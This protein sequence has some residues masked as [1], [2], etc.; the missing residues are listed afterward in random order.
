MEKKYYSEK[1]FFLTYLGENKFKQTIDVDGKKV[2]L[3]LDKF[4]NKVIKVL[5]ETDNGNPIYEL[6]I[7]IPNAQPE[8]VYLERGKSIELGYL[9]LYFDKEPEKDSPYIHIYT[10]GGG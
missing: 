1:K 2:T 7:S 5:K 6:V 9:N 4:L 8:T 3:T 10:K